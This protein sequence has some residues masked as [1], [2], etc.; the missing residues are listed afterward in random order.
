[1]VINVKPA[2]KRLRRRLY[3]LRSF[4]PG[5]RRRHALEKMVGP[6]GFWDQLQKYQ[7]QAVTQ[8]GLQPHHFLLDIGCGP[9]QGG[10][11][12]IRYLESGHYVGVDQNPAAIATG[13][14]EISRHGLAGKSPRLLVSRNFGDDQPATSTFDF[15]WMSQILYYFDEPTMHRL[16]AIVRRRLR[17]TGIMAGDILGPESDRSFLRPPLP[18]VHTPDSLDALAR[19]HGLQVSGLGTL[20]AF[21]Y[22]KRL[23]LGNNLLLQINHR[24]RPE[25]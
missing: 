18:P 15:I 19:D 12:F 25:S 4:V 6:L 24:F 13:Y 21:G 16:F 20:Y 17:A 8:L 2:L 11:A 9:L 1:M 14:E 5:W 3:G 7:L 22:P 10:A 23:G